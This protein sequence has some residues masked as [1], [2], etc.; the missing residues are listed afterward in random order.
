MH[1]HKEILDRWQGR[2]TYLTLFG[3][4]Y[5]ALLSNC[6]DPQSTQEVDH[7]FFN[8]SDCAKLMH[9]LAGDDGFYRGYWSLTDPDCRGDS[10]YWWVAVAGWETC[11]VAITMQKCLER[12]PM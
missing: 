5:S 7:S 6:N 11:N 4:R 3:N 1:D 2:H 8:V 12:A 9:L 10:D